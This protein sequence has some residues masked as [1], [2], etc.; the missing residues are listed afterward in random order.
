MIKLFIVLSL[1]LC[2]CF[3]AILPGVAQTSATAPQQQMGGTSS[4]RGTTAATGDARTYTSRRTVGITN[5]NAP[6]VFED[7]T[8][9]TALAKFRH[10]SGGKA[11][12]YI[13]E[14]PASG[15][16]IL[17]YDNDGRPDIYLLNGSTLAALRRTRTCAARRALPQPRQ[18]EV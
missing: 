7:V 17:D 15:V 3:C 12:N 16:A 4:S 14:T 11:K 6:V 9:R 10:Q 2:F 8:A 5:P 1:P 13:L 18:M